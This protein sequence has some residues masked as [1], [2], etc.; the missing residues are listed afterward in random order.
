MT[1]KTVARAAVGCALG[2][3]AL[4]AT[5]YAAYAAN[6]WLRFGRPRRPQS[7][8][9]RDPFLDI[10]IPRYDVV[11]RHQISVDAPAEVTLDAALDLRLVDSPVVRALF[12]MRELSLGGKPPAVQLRGGL[13]ESARALGWGVLAEDPHHEIVFGAVTKPWEPNPVFRAVAPEA[14]EAFAEP[15]FVKIVWTLR[16]DPAGSDRCVFRTETRAIATDAEARSK[17]RRYWALFSPGV[18]L[19]RHLMLGPVKWEA[20]RRVTTELE[21]VTAG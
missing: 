13:R 2:G 16:A 17:F 12:K 5:G 4:A 6:S 19:I 21:G 1:A 3:A 9:E 8:V 11:E 7:L 10:S 20:E 15:G 18:L 14:F